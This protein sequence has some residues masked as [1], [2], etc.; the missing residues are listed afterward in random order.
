MESADCRLPFRCSKKTEAAIK[1]MSVD[2]KLYEAVRKASARRSARE[3]PG[4]HPENF[5][6]RTR[7]RDCQEESL[8]SNSRTLQEVA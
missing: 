3:I 8:G 5:S 2:D 1:G 4:E 6:A 7:W